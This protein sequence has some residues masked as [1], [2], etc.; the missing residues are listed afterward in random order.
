MKEHLW[1]VS[2][3]WGGGLT[4]DGGLALAWKLIF[5]WIVKKTCPPVS[6]AFDQNRLICNPFSFMGNIIKW[7]RKYLLCLSVLGCTLN[8]NRRPPPLS[9]TLSQFMARHC[10]CPLQISFYSILHR[11]LGSDH[12]IVEGT[13]V[14]TCHEIILNSVQETS[15]KQVVDSTLGCYCFG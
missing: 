2:K 7:V 13:V 3:N 10:P 8:Y 14:N 9:I 15:L 11:K 12:I 1:L 4:N 6:G 5:L